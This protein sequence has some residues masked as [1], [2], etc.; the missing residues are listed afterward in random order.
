MAPNDYTVVED[1]LTTVPA[2]KAPKYD[3]LPVDCG[4]DDCVDL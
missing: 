2:R 4:A 1:I 3:E